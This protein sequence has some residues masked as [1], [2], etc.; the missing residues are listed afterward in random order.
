MLPSAT[1]AAIAT[2]KTSR[3]R[4]ISTLPFSFDS[5]KIITFIDCTTH[6]SLV[7]PTLT[8]CIAHNFDAALEVKLLHQIRFVSFYGLDTN[9]QIP[10]Y[11]LVRITPGHQSQNFRLPFAYLIS[12]W[13]A[14]EPA[15]A[16]ISTNHLPCQRR[17]QVNTAGRNYSNRFD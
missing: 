1:N 3:F 13:I 4:F 10:R 6:L 5:E 2:A 12:R 17:I 11:F 15:L 14:A 7:Q 16:E 9:S 8:Q